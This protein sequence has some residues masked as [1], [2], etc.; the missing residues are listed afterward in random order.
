VRRLLA[1]LAVLPLLLLSACGDGSSGPGDAASAS[2]SASLDDITVTGAFG[3]KPKIT[4]DAPFTTSTPLSTVVSKGDG[5]PVAD[6]QQVTAQLLT[7]DGG[8]GKELQSSYESGQPVGFPMSADQINP[9]LYDAVKG[10][11]VG[12]RV[13]AVVPGDSKDANS[14]VLVLDLMDAHTVPSRASGTAVTPP[15]GLPTVTLADNGAPTITLP[16]TPPPPELIVQPLITGKGPKVEQGQTIT[17]HYTG[18]K[19]PGG[20]V[21]DS[22]WE[23]GQPA[24]FPIGVGKVIPGWDAGLVGQPVGSQVLLVIPPKQGYGEQGQPSAG[25]KGTDTLVFVVDILDAT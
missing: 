14:V 7:L 15:P 11:P 4:F 8:T 2:S 19:W 24:Q 3:E 5:D 22:S 12:S 13:L 20:D 17:V 18:V 21:F 25:I 23:R 16:D 6:G 1:L 10:V 9:G